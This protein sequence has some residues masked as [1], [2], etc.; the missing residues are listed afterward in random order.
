MQSHNNQKAILEPFFKTCLQQVLVYK[1]RYKSRIALSKLDERMLV[2]I[3]ISKDMAK[4][5]IQKPFWKGDSDIF[6]INEYS[7]LKERIYLAKPSKSIWQNHPK[8]G[9]CLFKLFT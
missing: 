3:G 2:D 7:N 1:H 4:Q 9:G 5:E 8:V 6:D